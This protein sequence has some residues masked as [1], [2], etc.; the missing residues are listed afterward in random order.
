MS[1]LV[2]K[3]LTYLN[4]SKN[5]IFASKEYREQKQKKTKKVCQNRSVCFVC[6]KEFYHLGE[7][8]VCSQPCR[9]KF[10]ASQ[11][12]GSE[13][14]SRKRDEEFIN[15]NCANCNA[16]FSFSK[17][18]T[19][20]KED[21]FFC[22]LKCSS[23]FSLKENQPHLRDVRNLGRDKKFEFTAC[24]LCGADGEQSKLCLHHIDYNKEN[25]NSENLI[26]LCKSCFATVNVNKDFWK[27]FFTVVLAGS[28]VVKKGWGCEV[29]VVNNKYYCLKYLIF[30]PHKKFSNHFHILKKETWQCILGNF[31]CFIQD[32]NGSQNF[33]FKKGD[34]VTINPG[35]KHQLHALDYSVI[36][37]VSTTDYPEDSFRIKK[38]D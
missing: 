31:H 2:L 36:V 9:V 32:K 25:C 4:L 21:L 5:F 22:S 7:K 34:V 24:V 10:L 29:H 15:V 28:K 12:I 35:I 19:S 1:F 27:Y 38:G 14:S 20:T 17:I 23:E 11:K 37:E 3:L 8:I 13:I 33:L 30:F 26:T 18:G 6:K 16:Q